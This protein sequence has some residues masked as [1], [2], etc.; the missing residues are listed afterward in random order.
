M[1]KKELIDVNLNYLISDCI[2]DPIL[3]TDQN[4]DYFYANNSHLEDIGINK[5]D[6]LNQNIA[7]SVHKEDKDKVRGFI[8]NIFNGGNKTTEIR[9]KK[10][11]K[12]YQ[13]FE[14]KAKKFLDKQ[15]NEKLLIFGRRI[16]KYRRIKEEKED[17]EESFQEL[18][19]RFPELR[20]WK[21]LYPQSCLSAVDK[22]REMLEYVIDNIPQYIAWKDENSEYIGCNQE[23]AKILGLSSPKK[24]SGLTDEHFEWSKDILK[25]I[26]ESEKKVVKEN[27]II[28]ENQKKLTLPNGYE[29]WFDIN[30]IPLENSQEKRVGIL[31]SLNDVTRR[32]ENEKEVKKSREKLRKMNKILEQRVDEKTH[33]LQK[34]RENLKKKNIELKKKNKEL[35]R[36]DKVKNDFISMA[37]HAL[38]TPLVS[39]AG[40]TDYILMSYEDINDDIREDVEAVY[41]NV[42]RLEEYID[43]L[44]DVI[45]IDAKQ[46]RFDLYLQECNIY[47]IINECLSELEFQIEKKDLKIKNLIDDDLSLE[48]DKN[49]MSQVFSN[50]LSNSIKFTPD[51][52]EI[53]LTSRIENNRCH[54]NIQDTGIGLTA[55]EISHLFGKFVKLQES[56]DNFSIG[57]SNFKSGSGLGLYITKGIIEAHGGE[58]WAESKGKGKGSTFHFYL[59]FPR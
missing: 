9:F 22:A 40:Y 59:P 54:F 39:I 28:R 58:I 48:I 13:W 56:I 21:I 2:S 8:K 51:E 45:K 5:D 3:I 52:G 18:M 25:E 43:Q 10:E 34:S 14:L 20:F 23:Y 16:E 36:L 33:K 6:I 35:R 47:E 41:R 17:L 27:K 57:K 50:L 29:G 30:R 55:E 7:N 42:K 46:M 19:E 31:I 24:I 38:K 4:G 32:I 15:G 37:G 44:L 53:T 1:M 49:K 11:K 26:K 12:K